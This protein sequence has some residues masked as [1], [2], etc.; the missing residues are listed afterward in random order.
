[1]EKTHVLF[2]DLNDRLMN[3]RALAEALRNQDEDCEIEHDTVYRVTNL[4]M[5]EIDKARVMWE[6]SWNQRPSDAV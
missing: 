1:M 4:L 2:D 6:Q 5:E 3:A